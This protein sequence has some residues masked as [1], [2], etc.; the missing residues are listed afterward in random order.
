MLSPSVRWSSVVAII[1]VMS[2]ARI[3]SGAWPANSNDALPVSPFGGTQDLPVII[4]DGAGGAIMAWEDFSAGGDIFALRLLANGDL[5]PGWPSFGIAIC[6]Q[7]AA[8]TAPAICSDGVGGAIIVWEDARVNGGDIFAQRVSASGTLLWAGGSPTGGQQILAVAGLQHLPRVIPD[9]LG[10]AFIVWE[11]LRNGGANADIYGVRVNSLGAVQWVSGL[12]TGAGN[13]I[14]PK[15]IGGVSGGGFIV[16][17]DDVPSG[18]GGFAKAV[19][20]NGAVL[21]TAL[22]LNTGPYGWSM[23]S[24]N[25]GG[26][27]SVSGAGDYVNFSRA[28]SSGV[29]DWT[30]SLFS[31]FG[32]AAANPLSVKDGTG[33]M[34]ATWYD[35][36]TGAKALRIG[37]G[38]G[39]APSWP[40][41]NGLVLGASFIPGAAVADGSRGM[42]VFGSLSNN[43]GN[44]D[45]WAQH[46]TWDAQI[47]IE[48]PVAGAAISM[49]PQDQLGVQA[50]SDGAGGAIAVWSDQRSGV[51]LYDLYAQR[52]DFYGQLGN[53]EPKITLVRDVPSDQGGHVLIRWSA[54]YLDSVE[55]L[56]ENYQ[57]WRQVA[58]TVAQAALRSGALQVGGEA[59]AYRSPEA[60]AA[61]RDG[62]R[63]LQAVTTGATVVF[64]EFLA[65]LGAH[66]DGTYSYVA[67]TT[68][69]SSASYL[70]YTVFRVDAEDHMMQSYPLTP[71][72][73]FAYWK[74]TPDSGYSVDNLPPAP[75]GPFAGN[76]SG[77]TSS[78]HWRP[79]S[80]ADLR[81][82]RLYRGSSA[83]FQPGP[84]NMVVESADSAY[85]DAAGAPYYYKLS[86]IDTH[87]N[88]SGF[89]TL[90]PSGTAGVG[91]GEMVLALHPVIPNPVLRGAQ[92]HF[93]L[94][95]AGRVSL[96]ILDIAGRRMSRLVNGERSAGPQTAEWSGRGDDG[97]L[98]KSGV[99]IVELSAEGQL[100]HTKMLVTR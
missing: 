60:L 59:G 58:P 35:V 66:G 76:Y 34:I 11:D 32:A 84:T 25:L 18:G 5:A 82:Y 81:A 13:Q 9:E 41:S 40:T 51:G 63:V 22:N 57:V 39:S 89:T 68:S 4:S 46:V 98:L 48:W 74:S 6:T 26:L 23:V 7:A 44:F 2:S 30:M 69:D 42:I 83:N 100:L 12:A 97:A 50:V 52:I 65:S 90:L 10:G 45:L 15:L 31:S 17:Y 29:L 70:R 92:F 96:A 53:P 49:A 54:S 27:I 72:E 33:G 67:P 61:R 77:G 94:P 85:V 20:F 87:D 64:W 55:R 37:R 19:A 21:W 75:P 91:P 24:D 88:E 3:A 56:I 78:L 95:R 16:G 73:G 62:R 36:N 47:A 8:Q 93:N 71:R 14:N 43:A 79:S 80:E 86:A 99:Y 38:G 28:T 1:A